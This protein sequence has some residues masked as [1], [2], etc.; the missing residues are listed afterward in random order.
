MGVTL[1]LP[2]TINGAEVRT[3]RVYEGPSEVHRMVV[4]RAFL[5]VVRQ[6]KAPSCSFGAQEEDGMVELRAATKE[7]LLQVGRRPLRALCIDVA[8]EHVHAGCEPV[9][10]DATSNG[11]DRLYH[12][13]HPGA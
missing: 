5:A 3:M 9:A 11:R 4:A 1:E 2:L 12:A 10:G 13:L 8:C 6:S 7:A